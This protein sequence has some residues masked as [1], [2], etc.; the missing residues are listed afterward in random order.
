MKKGA[1]GIILVVVFGAALVLGTLT[2]WQLFNK[3]LSEPLAVKMQEAA[4]AVPVESSAATVEPTSEAVCGQ[5]GSSYV[6]LVGYHKAGEFAYQ[7]EADVVRLIK[8]DFDQKKASAFAFPRDLVVQ[9]PALN[10]SNIRLGD[11]FQ[12]VFEKEG[13]NEQAVPKALS[14]VAQALYDTYGVR[15]D[16]YIAPESDKVAQIV[17]I[18]GGVDVEMPNAFKSQG[19]GF[20]TLDLPAGLNHLNGSGVL[21]YARF[22]NSEWERAEHYNAVFRGAAQKAKDPAIYEKIP[23]LYE[24]IKEMVVTDMS[25]ADLTNL[26]CA[27]KEIAADANNIQTAGFQKSD[28]TVNGLRMTV[29]DAD[30]AK[31]L[32]EAT[33]AN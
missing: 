11:V 4:T 10:Q 25:L 14:A 32:I 30:A 20:D 28:L 24:Q 33:F 27:T 23:D 16:H 21:T 7:A 19:K 18:L 3:P 31:Q 12:T 13:S 22:P 17:D 5:T 6:L 9:A 29:K 2:V 8:V 1:A 15:V 26:A